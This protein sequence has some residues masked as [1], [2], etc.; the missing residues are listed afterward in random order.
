MRVAKTYEKGEIMTDA[1]VVGCGFAGAVAARQLAEKGK[2]VLLLEKRP[3]VGGNMF[4][5]LDEN[6]VPVHMYGPHIFHTNSL[7]VYEHITKFGEFESYEHRV[8]GFIDGKFVPIPFNF[9]SM[10]ELL[11]QEADGLRKLLLQ[12]FEGR[13]RVSVMELLGS[14]DE[15]IRRLGSFVYEKVFVGYTAKQWGIPASQV[16]SS[17][18]N[19]V[20]V[21][22]GYDDRYFHDTYQMMPRGTYT[23]IFENLLNHEKIELKLST[24]ALDL[25]EIRDRQIYFEGR[26]F[27]GA[28]V[29]TGPIDE[30][31]GFK[32][33]SLPYRSLHMEFEKVPIP[34]FQPAA[35]VNYPND[36][37][38]TRIT[39]FKHFYKKGGSSTT[40][41][42]EYPM[43]YDRS[44]P[45]GN[46]PYYV[47]PGEKNAELY[48]K[49]LGDAEGI[50]N[51][52]LIGRLAE[53]KYYNMDAAIERA[54][55]EAERIF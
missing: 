48:R 26:P 44:A 10:E 35:V 28:V 23:R 42:R 20:P 52:F 31:F 24:D 55:E 43:P 12:K 11:P 22:L 41:L 53:Y 30:L 14:D 6:G 16:D 13:E 2:K 4:D 51:L 3:H 54:L 17:V 34:Q 46:I 33:G 27:D 15:K 8:L 49:Y 36:N 45:K 5:V 25:M 7:R 50:K 1:I 32:Y 21:V 47:F 29:F 9:K 19:R 40:I 38:F 39:E 18:I 37:E